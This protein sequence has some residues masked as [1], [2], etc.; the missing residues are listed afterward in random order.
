MRPKS[1]LGRIP[2]KQSAD[3]RPA[4]AHQPNTVIARRANKVRPTRQSAQ[5]LRAAVA[6]WQSHGGI[7]LCC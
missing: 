7:H 3:P 4:Q 2:D 1:F 5:A 6:A